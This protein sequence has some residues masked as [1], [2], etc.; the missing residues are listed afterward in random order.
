M[1]NATKAYEAVALQIASPRELEANLLR[2][3]A[4]RLQAVHNNA[5][6][7]T[8]ELDEA[9][10]FN[11]KLW[12]ILMTSVTSPNNPLPAAIR[13]NVANLGIFVLNQTVTALG[14]PQPEQLGSLI[15][16]NREVAAGLM[17]RA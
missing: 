2:Q 7:R 13:Q 16:I 12:T 9:L 4:S 6:R 14:D 15:A 10:M 8:P 5:D 3:A 17:A 11:R 1:P